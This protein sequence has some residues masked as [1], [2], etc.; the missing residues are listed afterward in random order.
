[1]GVIRPEISTTTT[2]RLVVGR[3]TAMRGFSLAQAFTP[4]WRL[5]A[6]GLHPLEGA[7]RDAPSLQPIGR[8][9]KESPWKGLVRG[10]WRHSPQ[11]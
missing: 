9:P 3:V 2:T 5:R 7:Y 1:M 4:G 10:A 6:N 8:K 11:A